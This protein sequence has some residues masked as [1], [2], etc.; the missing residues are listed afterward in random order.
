[1]GGYKNNPKRKK[2]PFW[3]LQLFMTN[4]TFAAK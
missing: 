4:F 2:L 1:M 3:V